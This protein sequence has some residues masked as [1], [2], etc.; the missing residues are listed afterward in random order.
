MPYV[1][2]TR[3]ARGAARERNLPQRSIVVLLFGLLAMSV[4][5][6]GD[7]EE[8]AAERWSA[9]DLRAVASVLASR[10]IPERAKVER[11]TAELQARS[12]VWRA[13]K[14]GRV[15]GFQA[16]WL[17]V[18]DFRYLMQ[19]A[20]FR[21]PPTEDPRPLDLLRDV[22]NSRAE[23]DPWVRAVLRT[24]LVLAGSRDSAD[25]DSC[26]SIVRDGEEFAPDDLRALAMEALSG[27]C[28]KSLL[29]ALVKAFGS[30][31]YVYEMGTRQVRFPL[32]DAAAAR[33]SELGL[34]VQQVS[35]PSPLPGDGGRE[36]SVPAIETESLLVLLR[37]QVRSESVE[38][39]SAA[40]DVFR[41]ERRPEVV[42]LRTLLIQDA[43]LP[44]SVRDSLKAIR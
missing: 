23:S 38:D 18:G 14:R 15:V 5:V 2:T 41:V 24:C 1:A 20:A 40:V 9:L 21:R 12:V 42:E 34:V 33:L 11:V 28:P 39:A 32:R 8:D 7:G 31:W 3:A 6:V 10:D 19:F 17:R 44:K 27:R 35:A 37:A 16:E 36:L 26:A 22:I 29:A 13:A 25:L 30:T 4:E 43:S